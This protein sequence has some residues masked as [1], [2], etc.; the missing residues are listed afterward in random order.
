MEGKTGWEGRVE[1]CFNQRWGVVGG[2]GWTLTNSHVVCN[3]LGYDIT[4]K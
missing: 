4:G 1:M 2:N 3:S